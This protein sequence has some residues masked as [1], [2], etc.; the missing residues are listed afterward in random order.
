VK[1]EPS[2]SN[3]RVP[4]LETKRHSYSAVFGKNS[5]LDSAARD[6]AFAAARGPAPEPA[7]FVVAGDDCENLAPPGWKF[8]RVIRS[9]DNRRLF[10]IG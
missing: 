10:H 7:G 2:Q 6:P 1:T 5:D 9:H 4:Q 3:L 8:R